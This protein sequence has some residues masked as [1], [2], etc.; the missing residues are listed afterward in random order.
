MKVLILVGITQLLHVYQ[1]SGPLLSVYLAIMHLVF[2]K[3]IVIL[4]MW[5]QAS[6]RHQFKN[7]L[8]LHSQAACHTILRE[9][10]FDE[11]END[12]KKN[13]HSAFV[14]CLSHLS[15]LLSHAFLEGSMRK[16]KEGQ[17]QSCSFL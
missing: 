13:N 16:G 6:R 3:H 14:Y 11:E 5:L 10:L 1:R 15:T 12:E 7:H 4:Q 17:V 9:A 2:T 8:I